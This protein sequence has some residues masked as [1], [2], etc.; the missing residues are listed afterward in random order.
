MPVKQQNTLAL[1]FCHPQ[2]TCVNVP[3]TQTPVTVS[4]VE[5]DDD[6]HSTNTKDWTNCGSVPLKTEHKEILQSTAWLDDSL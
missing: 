2:H 1:F 3:I 5:R 4:I 6:T